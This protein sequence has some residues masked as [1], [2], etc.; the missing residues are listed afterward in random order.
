MF[1]VVPNEALVHYVGR[2]LPSLGVEGVPVTTF[3]RFASRLVAQLFP[4]LPTNVSEETPPV[5]SRA[6]SH[7]AMLRGIDAPRG[8][9]RR[10]LRRADARGM[11]KWP[12]A[13]QALAA[14]HATTAEGA[15]PPDMRIAVFS[16]WLAGKRQL[17][18]TAP[19]SAL[20]HV[21]RGALEQLAAD[22]RRQTRGVLGAW[23]ELLTSRELLDRDVRAGARVR[24]GPARSGSR[25]VRSSG[26]RAGRG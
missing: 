3:A 14:W 6:K 23:D 5:V 17:A 15:T 13:D 25:L 18:G 1:V 12:G 19:A 24:A 8:A 10:A 4:R 11:E 21:T 26:S 2:V 16:A 7:P 9:D 22:L 20:P